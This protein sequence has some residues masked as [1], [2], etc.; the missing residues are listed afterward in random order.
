MLC[1]GT[2]WLA[3]TYKPRL[4]KDEEFIKHVQSAQAKDNSNSDKTK[5]T[6]VSSSHPRP[7]SA[8]FA[9]HTPHQVTGYNI[10]IHNNT[11]HVT[12]QR[13]H[14]SHHVTTHRPHSAQ[15]TS[16]PGH[17][18]YTRQVTTRTIDQAAFRA[19]AQV[20]AVVRRPLSG[21]PSSAGR[22]QSATRPLGRPRS[23]W[24]ESDKQRAWSPLNN[25][26]LVYG[27]GRSG[28]EESR[29]S[30]PHVVHP[31]PEGSELELNFVSSQTDFDATPGRR[32][33]STLGI[34]TNTR[35]AS[36]PGQYQN[37]NSWN[38]SS[39][40]ENKAVNAKNSVPTAQT[41]QK[42]VPQ[43]NVDIWINDFRVGLSVG[44]ESDPD[45]L[46]YDRHSR[47]YE[48]STISRP[49]SAV[50]RGDNTSR[51]SSALGVSGRELNSPKQRYIDSHR[52][53]T[54]PNTVR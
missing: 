20:R 22:P 17:G 36:A 26:L 43:D 46:Y 32:T 23:A 28:V 53:R 37:R 7:H 48:Q 15:A 51:P 12:K 52:P 35:P 9:S 6:S 49:S 2:A 3:D 50:P 25:G 4:I 29:P 34:N 11:S 19:K 10:E 38:C 39:R 42:G 40:E 33:S 24:A 18:F 30:S 13:P 47:C 8:H 14:S 41:Q 1:S 54:A 21:R 31:S 27:S 5:A 44:F 45:L 16:R